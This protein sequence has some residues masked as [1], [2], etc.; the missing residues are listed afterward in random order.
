MGARD[1]AAPASCLSSHGTMCFLTVER[2]PSRET[3]RSF[4]ERQTMVS[5]Q[6]LDVALPFGKTM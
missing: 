4:I 2:P 5:A 6:E 3:K 1:L